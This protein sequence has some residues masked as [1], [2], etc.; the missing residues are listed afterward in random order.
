M[1]Y[2]TTRKKLILPEYGRCIQQMVDYIVSIENRDERT[3]LA[4]SLI[5]V[6]A[7]M[8]PK[9]SDTPDYKN[10]LWDHLFIMSDFKLD[11][12]SPYPI[13]TKETYVEKPQKIEYTQNG[14]AHKH[15]GRI[16]EDMVK[17]AVEM[18]E[19]EKRDALKLLI[20]N[21]MKK[22]N[23]SWNKDSV[24]DEDIFCDLYKL[25]Q[26]KLRAQPGT[27]LVDV[28][29]MKSSINSGKTQNNGKK[30]GKRKRSKK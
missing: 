23:V 9:L 14:V 2:N 24:S 6:M 15:Y 26:G 19:G 12:D 11:V 25:S 22:T 3:R 28:K 1:D 4:K 5:G 17:V 8:N 20:A 13:P 16:I 10:K 30:N 7:N 29:D 18:E 27:K 21:Q